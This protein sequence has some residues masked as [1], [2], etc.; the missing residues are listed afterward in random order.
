MR[1]SRILY[2]GLDV[3]KESIAV[4]NASDERDAEAVFLS[5]IGTCHSDSSSCSAGVCH[6]L[7]PCLHFYRTAAS[8]G[9]L[10]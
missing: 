3:H 5:P 2:V 10:R 6:G 4:A 8:G 9:S 1:R 7:S